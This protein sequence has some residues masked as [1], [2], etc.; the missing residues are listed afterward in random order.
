MPLDTKLLLEQLVDLA[1][2][3]GAEIMRHYEQGT[4]VAEKADRSPVTAADEA[5]EAIILAGLARLTPDIPVVAEEAVAKGHVP[6]VGDRPFWLV[7]P[8]DGTK[9][10]IQ[11]RGEFTVNIGL[12]EARRP[13]LGVVLA[14]A[15]DTAWWGAVGH[16]A[17]RRKG[18]RTETITV[19]PEPAAGAR[20]AVASRS[21]RDAATDAWLG[22]HG[23]TE[24]ISCG[25]SLKFCAV[26]EGRADVYPRFGRTMEWDT[27][28]GHAVLRAAGGE[29]TTTTGKPFLYTKPDFANDHGF[30]AWAHAPGRSAGP[31][32]TSR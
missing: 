23:I 12:V 25:S 17:R 7:D 1:D 24:T 19:R 3:A 21:H 15:I 22:E 14:P 5:G 16:G 8:L 26:A 20:V 4:E 31:A 32:D 2:A 29:V 10:F 27:G 13:V 18:G 30:I 11:K 28:A 9:E 6:A